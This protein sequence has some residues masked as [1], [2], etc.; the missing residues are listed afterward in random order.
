M[1]LQSPWYRGSSLRLGAYCSISVFCT[2]LLA[3]SAQ[4]S[5][6]GFTGGYSFSNFTLTNAGGQFPNG[7]ASSP[8]SNTVILTGSDDGS[9]LAGA[10]DLTI[11][12]LGDGLFQ[13]S[14]D[15]TTLD[16][17]QDPASDPAGYLV[18]GTFYPFVDPNIYSG[19]VAVPVV[20]GDVIGFRVATT[21]NSFGPGVLTITDFNAPLA[22]VPEPGALPLLLIGAMAIGICRNRRRFRSRLVTL[23]G[24][25]FITVVITSGDTPAMA[26]V[27]FSG[28][29]VTGEL[30][31]IGVV[32]VLNPVQLSGAQ[33]FA[34]GA[35]QTT[36]P[37]SSDVFAL[38]PRR[39]PLLG[40]FATQ[41]GEDEK[42]RP[43]P[44]RL[45]PPVEPPSTLRPRGLRAE[46]AAP[47]IQGLTVISP[48][49]GDFRFQ[50][51][52][53]P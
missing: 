20:S 30:Q 17:F 51:H 26:Q 31:K 25:V 53:A 45:H 5:G 39:M 4:G 3:G 37:H 6:I 14:Y 48:S 50:R 9:G 2:F 49:T 46:V 33:S 15:Y 13:F 43:P 27:F 23:V 18:A 29:N 42:L 35:L 52:F 8:D 7:Y 19:A 36:Q 12:A 24:I 34:A 10:T 16:I 32:D 28:T 44:K 11:V 40:G 47:P 38:N 22:P 1:T 21:D 41:P